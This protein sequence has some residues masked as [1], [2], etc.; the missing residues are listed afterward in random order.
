RIVA[1]QPGLVRSS[2]GVSWHAEPLPEAADVDTL[3][4]AGGDGVDA[5]M[6]DDATCAFVR[7]CAARSIRVASVCSGSLLLAAA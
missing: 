1:A 4:V 7:R 5:A 2:S 6:T 3:L